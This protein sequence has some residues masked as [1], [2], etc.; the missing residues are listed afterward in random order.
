MQKLLLIPVL[1]CSI[2][3]L[4]S[5]KKMET[6]QRTQIENYL[7]SYNDFNV[8]GMLTD[9]DKDLVFE[10][11]SG[12]ELTHVIAGLE[13]FEQQAIEAK[14]YF[15]TRKQVITSWDFEGDQVRINVDYHAILAIDF[16]NGMKAGDTL[17]LKGR[18]V[19]TFDKGKILKIEDRS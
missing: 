4:D 10:N 17:D 14:S 3:C 5:K 2:S 16:P 12:D 9:L 11:Y 13:A 8:P 6:Q 7:Q 15:T 1:I 19:F 18:S